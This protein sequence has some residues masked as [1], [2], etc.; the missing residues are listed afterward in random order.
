M[1][2][3]EYFTTYK[4]SRL[5]EDIAQFREECTGKQ[6]ESVVASQRI[7]DPHPQSL[8]TVSA[9]VGY[10]SVYVR[11]TERM[12]Y[13][14]LVTNYPAVKEAITY[15]GELEKSPQKV[16]TL[17][18]D[19]GK[20][21][22]GGLSHLDFLVK[23]HGEFTILTLGNSQWLVHN[24]YIP[25]NLHT[26]MEEGYI[27]DLG[28]IFE[29]VTDSVRSYMAD[30]GWYFLDEDHVISETTPI[31]S[32]LKALL[33]WNG[34]MDS[35]DLVDQTIK[36]R[37][38]GGRSVSAS[39]IKILLRDTPDFKRVSKSE[40]TLD[41]EMT[42][43]VDALTTM[44]NAVKAAGENGADIAK[45]E[46]IFEDLGYSAQTAYVYASRTEFERRDGRIF[47]RD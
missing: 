28:D 43:H 42:E 46:D 11:Q 18:S 6:L 38:T 19:L 34:V 17:S 45:L 8:R 30:A 21:I 47:L 36:A 41:T 22:G 39:R 14:K 33:E 4:S 1:D 37:T 31:T 16:D 12:L 20:D 2:A 32:I 15:L 35:K 5:E 27:T 23:A 25:L 44:I 24:D 13:K 26:Y 10:S 40:W 7:F 9:I 29:T 3:L